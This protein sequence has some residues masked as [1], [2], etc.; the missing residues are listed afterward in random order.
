MFGRAVPLGLGQAAASSSITFWQA[1]PSPFCSEVLS[2]LN[3]DGGERT[4]NTV[5][6]EADRAAL[7]KI[8]FL[9]V[10][11]KAMYSMPG[12][13]YFTGLRG[14][15]CEESW[16]N[17]LDVSQNA[18]LEFLNCEFNSIRN[19]D[20]STNT[21]LVWLECGRNFLTSLDVSNNS[22]LLFLDCLPVDVKVKIDVVGWQGKG[23][24][25]VGEYVFCAEGTP[26][27]IYNRYHTY[28]FTRD[29]IVDALDLGIVLLY[30]GHDSDSPGWGTLAKV[31]DSN[32]R[33]VTV[34]MC[35]AN[36]DG[37]IDMLDVLDTCINYSMGHQV[38]VHIAPAPWIASP[39]RG[40]KRFSVSP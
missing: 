9:D 32:G 19:L 38:M 40:S 15:W 29:G 37:V 36:S 22:K 3:V 25:E 13:G 23:L 4:V 11:N 6:D 2:I 18:N 14:L 31:N 12:I 27:S 28:D 16:L 39:T 5:M 26:C 10:S 8:E 24:V 33:P 21:E 34:R 20:V 1:F 7:A 17:S 30:C 35:D